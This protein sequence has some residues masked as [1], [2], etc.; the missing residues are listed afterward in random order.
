MGDLIVILF[1]ALLFLVFG[2]AGKRIKDGRK[3]TVL[4]AAMMLLGFFWIIAQFNRELPQGNL[5]YLLGLFGPGVI[6]FYIGWK[7][8]LV[9]RTDN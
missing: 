4:G 3:S 7:L 6:S 8:L 2:Y 9:K 1:V 5:E